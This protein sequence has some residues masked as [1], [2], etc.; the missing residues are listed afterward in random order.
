MKKY[1]VIISL[2]IIII[3]AVI[4][5]NVLTKSFEENIENELSNI[6]IVESDGIVNT[7]TEEIPEEV[8]ETQEKENEVVETN[9]FSD[10]NQLES[11]NTIVEQVQPEVS[12]KEIVKEPIKQEIVNQVEP[13]KEEVSNPPV[14]EQIVEPEVN[15][16]PQVAEKEEPQQDQGY[17]NAMKEVE[18]LTRQ[19]C[20]DAGMK[21]A[22]ADTVGILGYSVQELYYGGKIIGYKL[23]IRYAE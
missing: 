1:V 6:N 17:I 11:Q 13:P 9:I 21:L 15:V 7:V 10:D 5:Y 23:I 14:Q 19:E 3:I 22:F 8:T 16:P 18:Y 2:V 4:V 12:T 20:L